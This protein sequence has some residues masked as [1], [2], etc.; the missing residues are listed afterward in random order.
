MALDKVDGVS[1]LAF[2]LS[3][4]STIPSITGV[5]ARIERP[6]SSTSSM[7]F[8][9][10][11]PRPVGPHEDR[12]SLRHSCL[13]S[14]ASLISLNNHRTGRTRAYPRDSPRMAQGAARPRSGSLRT[15]FRSMPVPCESAIDN[16]EHCG[17]NRVRRRGSDGFEMAVGLSAIAFSI[18]WT[19]QSL[20]KKE[21]KRSRRR[22]CVARAA[23]LP[24]KRRSQGGPTAEPAPTHRKSGKDAGMSSPGTS[25]AA[26]PKI[27]L[28]TFQ[29]DPDN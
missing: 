9:T 23:P 6:S 25:F 26:L 17:L 24:E 12:R 1:G 27:H 22:K 29:T 10:R 18:R 3:K 15:V 19:G 5:F 2:D 7:S 28:K 4:P 13:R 16:P 14:R 11:P 20:R 21:R 8:N